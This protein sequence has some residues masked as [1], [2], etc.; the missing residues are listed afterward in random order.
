MSAV[1]RKFWIC[2]GATRWSLCL[3]HNFEP[4]AILL[5]PD[6]S[7]RA[8]Y[9]LAASTND[10]THNSNKTGYHGVLCV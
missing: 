6:I 3:A 9:K 5:V 10:T 2:D 7:F 1:Q 8:A 4:V